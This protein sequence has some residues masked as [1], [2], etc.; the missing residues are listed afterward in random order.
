L[1]PD[2]LFHAIIFNLKYVFKVSLSQK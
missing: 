1:S 2:E